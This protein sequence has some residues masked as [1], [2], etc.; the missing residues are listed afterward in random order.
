MER[1]H[2]KPYHHL[3]IRKDLSEQE[4][5]R[6]VEYEYNRFCLYCKMK[7]EIIPEILTGGPEAIHIMEVLDMIIDSLNE[8]HLSPWRYTY[9]SYRADYVSNLVYIICKKDNIPLPDATYD[10]VS[11]YIYPVAVMT[12]ELKK[13][14]TCVFR[15][16]THLY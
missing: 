13:Y 5:E 14:S 6:N 12:I 2:Y 7:N 10:S 9:D 15:H 4:Q 11:I 3:N 1:D 8:I 16:R